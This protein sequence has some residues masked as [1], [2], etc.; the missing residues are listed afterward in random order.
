[1]LY[2]ESSTQ[3]SKLFHNIESPQSDCLQTDNTMT[4][5]LNFGIWA[6]KVLYSHCKGHDKRKLAPPLAPKWLSQQ[7]RVY[8]LSC[9]LIDRLFLAPLP[10]LALAEC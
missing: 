3:L 1:M 10:I 8:C 2:Y 7:M 5:R 9:V 4:V 6:S